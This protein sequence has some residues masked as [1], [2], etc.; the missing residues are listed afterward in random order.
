MTQKQTGGGIAFLYSKSAQRYS[1]SIARLLVQVQVEVEV[2]VEVRMSNTTN[3]F[4]T[5]AEE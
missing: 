3:Q 2:Q 4:W 5:A 1:Y